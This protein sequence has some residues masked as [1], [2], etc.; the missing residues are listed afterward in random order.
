[1]LSK[2]QILRFAVCRTVYG[3][4]R[5]H[6]RHTRSEY[7][8][9]VIYSVYYGTLFS[10]IWNRMCHIRL[11]FFYAHQNE[12]V[13]LKTIHEKIKTVMTN[14]KVFER[15]RAQDKLFYVFL[16]CDTIDSRINNKN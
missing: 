15:Q 11:D 5:I 9:R 6:L 13:T 14:D 8:T 1:M 16:I 7:V 2:V 4:E 12:F 3:T 10:R